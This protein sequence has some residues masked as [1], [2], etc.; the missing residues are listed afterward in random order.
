MGDV[1]CRGCGEPWDAYHLR[2]EMW[3]DQ[4]PCPPEA[5]VRSQAEAYN[6]RGEFPEHLRMAL[7]RG[8]WAFG[9]TVFDVRRCPCCGR[10]GLLDA[11]GSA[12]DALDEMA[13]V[14]AGDLDAMQ[15]EA[16][17]LFN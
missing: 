12:G 16:E 7:K 10:N 1:R 3:F 6:M 4:E 2:H 11:E 5:W 8:G 14:L 13:D 17:D 9:R 15:A